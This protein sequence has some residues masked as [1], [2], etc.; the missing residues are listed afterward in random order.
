MAD[1]H[2]AKEFVEAASKILLESYVVNC[3]MSQEEVKKLAS[4][5]C[6][7]YEMKMT[8]YGEKI[9]TYCG[10]LESEITKTS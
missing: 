5:E 4:F 10:E 1:V 7:H 2:D 6:P 8:G 3:G 9:C